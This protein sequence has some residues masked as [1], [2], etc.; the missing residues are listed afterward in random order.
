[1]STLQLE[2]RDHIF[3]VISRTEEYL[4]QFILKSLVQAYGDSWEDYLPKDIGVAWR[5]NQNL[6]DENSLANQRDE[7]LMAD[8][9]F[10]DLQTI[11]LKNW[12][13]VFSKNLKCD[14]P[15]ITS[16][17]ETIN[18]TRTQ[19]Y[20]AYPVYNRDLRTCLRSLEYN[21]LRLLLGG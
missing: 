11:I 19:A 2:V 10:K 4:R 9:Y 14:K 18:S 21:R 7:E 1:M 17:L 6:A 8:A 20:H 3:T 13:N 15:K 5:E 12:S 16:N